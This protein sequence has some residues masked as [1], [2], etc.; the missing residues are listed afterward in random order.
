MIDFA[1]RLCLSYRVPL[2][3]AS[4]AAHGVR[5][6]DLLYTT[7]SASTC[8][9]VPCNVCNVRST[10]YAHAC[11]NVPHD[12][13]DT[14]CDAR[15]WKSARPADFRTQSCAL[16]LLRGTDGRGGAL[17]GLPDNRRRRRELTR[18]ARTERHTVA[19]ANFDKSWMATWAKGGN[20]G[21][22]VEICTTLSFPPGKSS[23]GSSSSPAQVFAPGPRCGR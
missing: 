9:R 5:C 12:A 23:R 3:A 10:E 14:Q 20:V 4:R 6:S 19:G 21:H 1:L 18:R 17:H 2:C 16:V 15:V 22:A 7:R 11:L 8:A 13:D